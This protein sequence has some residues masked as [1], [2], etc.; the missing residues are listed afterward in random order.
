M[1]FEFGTKLYYEYRA[2]TTFD[3]LPQSVIE[4]ILSDGRHISPW[5][6]ASVSNHFT[7]LIYESTNKSWDYIDSA[8]KKSKVSLRG[9]SE[10]STGKVNIAKSAMIGAGRTY[11]EKEHV[12]YLQK[13]DG[14]HIIAITTHGYRHL[15]LIGI[16]SDQL[17]DSYGCPKKVIDSNFI[18]D[19][20]GLD[21][22]ALFDHLI[23]KHSSVCNQMLAFNLSFTT[24][25]HL[26]KCA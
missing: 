21:L 25:A 7:N 6:E 18:S 10:K 9:I 1:I 4:N 19:R 12:L 26:A 17:I 11:N 22:N 2:E 13:M 23:L 14:G 16:P 3:S 20:I 8:N 24:E 15:I 5:N